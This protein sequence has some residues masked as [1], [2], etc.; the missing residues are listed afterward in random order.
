MLVL[1]GQVTLAPSALAPAGIA[2][3]HS[4]T[5]FAGSVQRAMDDAEAQLRGLARQTA[6]DWTVTARE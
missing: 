3:A 4:I 1:A 6:A 5:D 2:A